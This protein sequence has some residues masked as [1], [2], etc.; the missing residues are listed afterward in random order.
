MVS[1]SPSTI[2]RAKYIPEGLFVPFR[3]NSLD[4]T[5]WKSSPN[6]WA[7]PNDKMK[8]KMDKNGF[9]VVLSFAEITMFPVGKM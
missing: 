8:R 6:I 1:V 5:L 9:I 3:L 7:V 4:C 2:N